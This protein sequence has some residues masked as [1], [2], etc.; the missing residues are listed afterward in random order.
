MEIILKVQEVSSTRL[1]GLCNLVVCRNSHVLS[2][3]RRCLSHSLQQLVSHF[4]VFIS[5]GVLLDSV[6]EVRSQNFFSLLSV[7]PPE[8]TRHK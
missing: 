2:F 4:P 6:S 1:S 7:S 3:H 5:A 8:A